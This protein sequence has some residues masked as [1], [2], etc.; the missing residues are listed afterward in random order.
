MVPYGHAPERVFEAAL[1][2]VKFWTFQLQVQND[3]RKELALSQSAGLIA[4]LKEQTAQSQ[5]RQSAVEAQLREVKQQLATVKS[6][7]R[8]LNNLYSS[9]SAKY[10]TEYGS[11]PIDDSART[12]AIVSSRSAIQSSRGTSPLVRMVSPKNSKKR[13]F[14]AASSPLS[15]L[16]QPTQSPVIVPQ[17][18][19][20]K[21]LLVS[22][23][24][25]FFSFFFFSP[26][27][28]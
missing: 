3:R 8:E 18:A 17:Q 15:F 9:L 27:I 16:A 19:P 2:A 23:R 5:Q 10:Q 4:E 28:K 21:K 6:Q 25:L 7:K 22:Q 20:S 1:K 12:P 24:N 13:I 11:A 26:K 14:S